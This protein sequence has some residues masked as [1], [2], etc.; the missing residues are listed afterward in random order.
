MADPVGSGRVSK[1][2]GYLLSKGDFRES[3]PNLPQR[4]AI[5]GEANTANQGSLDLT[6]KLIT[7]AQQA[8]NLYGFGSPLHR[9]LSILKPSNGEGIGGIPIMVYPQEEADGATEKIFTIEPSGVATK[10]GTHYLV[11]AGRDNINGQFYAINILEGDTTSDIA[12]KIE[13]AVNA[14]LGSPV[15]AESDDYEAQL[16]SKWKGLTAE[17][18]TLSV[19]T[20]DDDL[21]ITYSINSTQAGSATPDIADALTSFGNAWE[22]IVLNTYGTPESIMAALEAFNGIADPESPSGRYGG[23]IFKPFIAVTGSVVDNPSAITDARKLNMTIA[24]A[25]APL[26][27]GLPMEAAANMVYLFAIQAQ[28]SPHLDVSGKFYPD[29]PTPTDIGSMAN[30]DSRDEYVKKGC[31]TV[32][33]VAGKYKVMDFV[34]TYHPDGEEPPQFRY[35]RNLNLDWNVRYGYFLLEEINVVD[36]AI[37][38]D[39]DTVSA[40]KVVKPKQWKGI[41]K[42]YADDLALRALIVDP[43]FMKGAITVGLSTSNPD[44]LETFF[45]YKR[46]GFARIS[47]TEAQAG[48]NFGTLN[49]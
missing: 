44:R 36:H 8:G 42:K 49:V 37:A 15:T 9:M 35:C 12:G 21:G 17:G 48:F 6:P 7:T 29:M 46:S 5:L 16:T 39:N 3:S 27:Q 24:I 40:T 10:N 43:D 28:D 30:Y 1:V 41:L 38:R 2:V 32:D 33:L 31:S 18:I 25:P 23:T 45:R 20:D 13:D 34:T 26:S 11:I 4:V 19:D 47:S 14:V 22:T